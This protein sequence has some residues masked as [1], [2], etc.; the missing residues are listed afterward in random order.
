MRHQTWRWAADT[1][2]MSTSGDVAAA[3]VVLYFGARE[4]IERT[5][6]LD[7]LGRAHPRATLIGCSSGGEILGCD[8]F[9]GG[10]VAL[11]LE[12]ERCGTRTAVVPIAEAGQSREAGAALGGRLAAADLRW[13]FVLSD[14]MRVNGSELVRGLAGSVGPRVTVTGG[15]AGDG[16]RFQRTLVGC[17]GPPLSGQ[18]AALGVYGEA[19]MVGHGS[20]GGWDAFGPERVITRAKGNVLYELDGRPALALYKRYLGDEARDLPGS[21][22]LF[23]LRIRPVDGRGSD[24]VRTIVNVDEAADAL[25]FAGDVPQGWLAQLMKGN[26]NRL[27]DGAGEAA[28]LAGRGAPRSGAAAIL[29]SCIGRKLLLGQRIS[30]EA[31]ATAEL[32]GPEVSQLGFYS[33]GEISPHIRSGACELHNQTMTVTLLAES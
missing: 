20:V 10:I 2:W 23:P 12:F 28:R 13:V 32:L 25:V 3:A 4:A 33:Y 6:A 17:G 14:G 29:I 21:G 30:D 1:G 26:F 31:E 22:L 11:A 16:D 18:V 8:V 24:V 7:R 27:I 15:L 9:D 5:G 19:L